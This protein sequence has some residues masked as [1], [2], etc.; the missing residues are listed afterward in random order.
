MDSILAWNVQIRVA[1]WDSVLDPAGGAYGAPQTPYSWEG[2]LPSAIA[3]SRLRACNL[4]DSQVSHLLDL[5]FF[6]Q[7]PQTQFLD[8]PLYMTSVPY[9]KLMNCEYL[10][11][12][13]PHLIYVYK[14]SL[15]IM[16][17]SE[18]LQISVS[19]KSYTNLRLWPAESISLRI[20][21]AARVWFAG[22]LGVRPHL[23][24]LF[25]HVLLHY[26]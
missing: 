25:N 6:H 1:S 10:C 7:C 16:K 15:P 4:P 22:G 13:C 20:L 11:S 24:A 23:F 14:P 18:I 9:V 26:K 3:A 5:N 2:F 19:P 21:T 12:L 8:P 17:K